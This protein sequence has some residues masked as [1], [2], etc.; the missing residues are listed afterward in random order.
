MAVDLG[1]NTKVTSQL[2][3]AWHPSTCQF[4]GASDWWGGVV[5][6]KKAI[7]SGPGGAVVNH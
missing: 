6:P 3:P 5:W 7:S 4:W 1:D 2:P